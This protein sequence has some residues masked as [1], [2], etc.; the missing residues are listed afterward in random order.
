MREYVDRNIDGNME[1]Y[2]EV[3]TD[4]IVSGFRNMIYL[5]NKRNKVKKVLNGR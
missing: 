3:L 2:M 1:T 5:A 4:K